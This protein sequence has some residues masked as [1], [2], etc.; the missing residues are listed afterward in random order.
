M[1]QGYSNA[2]IV[3][4]QGLNLYI[5]ATKSTTSTGQTN[6]LIEN[7]NSRNQKIEELIIDN[8]NKDINSFNPHQ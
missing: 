7:V 3:D 4:R 1:S 6:N 8:C 2:S 5:L